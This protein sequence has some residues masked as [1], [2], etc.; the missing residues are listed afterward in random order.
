MNFI[1]VVISIFLFCSSFV[2]ANDEPVNA[3]LYS[4]EYFDY[5]IEC[6]QEE[7]NRQLEEEQQQQSEITMDEITPLDDIDVIVDNYEPFKLKIEENALVNNY[8]ET[9]IKEDSKTIIPVG[10]KFGFFQDMRQTRNKYNSNDYRILAGAEFSASK[11]FSLASG[12]ETNF[13]GIDQNPTSRK[14]YFTPTFKFNDKLSLSF[15]NKMNIQSKAT[16][17]DIGV[18]ISP[19]KSKAMDF[20]V[21]AGITREQT[22]AISES[23]YFTTNFHLF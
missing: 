16:D 6:A 10:D 13:R 8:K 21:Y 20:G 1:G 23:I 22:G 18:N 3:Y 14:L 2:F 11:Y 9:F 7:R 19:F 12:M 5:L 4:E 15:H 17:N